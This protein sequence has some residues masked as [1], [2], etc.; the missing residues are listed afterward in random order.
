M[1]G[2]TKNYSEVPNAYYSLYNNNYLPNCYKYLIRAN[3]FHF[4]FTFLETL[5]NII[6]ELYIFL[7]GYNPEK[8]DERNTLNVLTFFPEHI[9]NLSI[10]IKVL[11]VL[12]YLLIF[13]GVYYILGKYKCKKS[14]IYISILFNFIELF[15]FRISMLLFLSVYCCLS[16]LCI[17]IFLFLLVPHIYITF[18]HFHYNH[19]YVFVPSFIIYPFDEFSS[20]FDICSLVIKILF[21]IV[22]Y[23][24]NN[25]LKKNFYV[26]TFIL[27]IIFCIYFINDLINHSYLLMKN[28]ALNKAKVSLFFIQTILLI[29]AQ[30][31]GA[32]GILN[33]SF[34]II[35]IFIFIIVLLYTFMLYDPYHHINIKR[36][37]PNENMIFF[38]FLLS[39]EMEPFIMIE[40]HISIHYEI[41]GICGLCNKFKN[42]LNQNTKNKEE[43]ESLGDLQNYKG[44]EELV[45][46]FFGILYDGRNKYFLLI[47]EMILAYKNKKNY[48]LHICSYL[49][50]N[51]SF[52]KFSE[53]NNNNF[54]L[55]LNIKILLDAM[56]KENKLLDIHESQILQI[57]LCNQFLSLV[58]LTL[59]QIN[60][61]MKSDENK[62][63]KFLNLSISLNKMKNSEYNE[64]LFSHKH[65]NISN[66]RNIIYLCALLYEEIFNT[67][68]NGNP[69]PLRDNFQI[70]EN[71]INTDK[72]D[73]VI[74]LA[75]NLTNKQCKII[76]AGKDLYSY[77]DNNLFDLIPLIFKDYLEKVFISKIV[78]HFSV[79]IK[80]KKLEYNNSLLEVSNNSISR[81]E[82]K[83]FNRSNRKI[84]IKREDS[85]YKHIAR[86]EYMEFNLIISQE[87]KSKSFY[88]LLNLK[89]IPLFNYDYNSY[90]ILLDG[91]FKLYKN[92][93]MTL[94]DKNFQAEN[95]QKILSVSKPEL[96]FPP[97]IYSMTFHKYLSSIEKKNYKL[98]KIFEFNLSKKLITIYS[99]IAKDK[100]AYKKEK[101]KSF[102][103]N[104]TIK[105]KFYNS[106]NHNNEKKIDVNQL[107]KFIEDNASV[108]SQKTVYNNSSYTQGFNL[109]TKRKENIYRDSKLYKIGTALHLM[110]PIIIIF[111]VIEIFHLINLKQGDY[112]NNYSLVYFNEFYKLYFQLFST[113]VSVI[114]IKYNSSCV[115]AMSL[116]ANK[117]NKSENYFNYTQYFY[118]ES[119]VLMKTLLG[120]RNNL[121]NIHQN[122]GEKNFEKIFEQEVNYTRISKIF[123]NGTVDLALMDIKIIFTEAILIAI[124]SFQILTNNT[125]NEEIYLLNKKEKP[126]LY[127][128]NYGN[129]TKNISDYQKEFYEMILNYEIFW[130]QFRYVYYKLL[131]ALSV[132]TKNIKFYIYFYFNFS[133]AIIAFICLMLFCYMQYFEYLVV[134]IMNHI[135][136][137]INT[138]EDNFN[139]FK[140]FSKKIE[141]LNIILKIYCS[142]PIKSIHNLMSS[143]N[144]Y[145]K[146][147]SNKKKNVYLDVNKKSHK[148]LGVNKIYINNFHDIPKHL[149]II[150]KSD[151][152]N[153]KIMLYYYLFFITNFIFI[154]VSYILLY[155]MWQKYYLI[156]DN[157]YSLLKKDTELEISFYKVMNIYDLII[158][159]N[160][161]LDDLAKDIF[162]ESYFKVDD[163][164]QLLNSFYDDLYQVFNYEF[165]IVILVKY[166]AE[167]FPYFFFSCDN[168]YF[169][170]NDYIEL[171][172]LNPEIK[173]IENLRDKIFT[174]C[175]NTGWDFNH[176][177]ANAFAYHHQEVRNAIMLITDFSYEGLINNLKQGLYGQIKLNLNLILNFITDIINV[178][179]HKVEYDNLLGV[180][181]QYLA[182]TIVVIVIIDIIIISIVI[183]F[184]IAR[185]KR[186]CDQFILL[187]QVFKLCEVHEQ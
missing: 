2:K 110:I 28:T 55:V 183:T 65:D 23:T 84:S 126:F 149:K 17:V 59:K 86:Y 159:D 136:M 24:N 180:L 85:F 125:I 31:M 138:K 46:S 73:R 57:T 90:Y 158:F 19:L 111:T 29:Y 63:F 71:L 15:Y 171:L 47:K 16:S 155:F 97:E 80:N 169:M 53:L 51:L 61:V 30:I 177:I 92:T 151:I 1:D 135:N 100:E 20:L 184:Y 83:L 78:E 43:D 4:V 26:I 153:L 178:K 120:R 101:R 166:F 121:L 34:F 13:D 33:I 69:L 95:K 77:K 103:A 116:Y 99:I 108:Q 143:Y 58:D 128:D 172:E 93:V 142:N 72:I 185:L 42:Y 148:N 11:I 106:E 112:I 157:L 163:G 7:K 122:I 140:E 127:F 96:E 76:R 129:N 156:K 88:R 79:K 36:E 119:Q 18:Y 162:H 109:K 6:Q 115:N 141:N 70:L 52:L 41:C 117:Y 3:L 32:K 176:D 168:M 22:G 98:F 87:F 60:N 145:E 68:I 133:Y 131:D 118:G 40:K 132:Q 173:Q 74:S 182:T 48:L 27:Q 75:L 187:K 147:L 175:N 134:N 35:F 150:K 45:N 38:L 164:V 39:N 8:E 9:K 25:Y 81:V 152:V 107:Q 49:F 181:A 165:E 82:N 21:S 62:A 137:V 167:G 91:W 37:T 123:N 105:L 174:I 114:C 12:L 124:N 144:K 154:V 14:N 64:V 67:T 102:S 139:F 50:I 104:E 94:Q 44:K 179:L 89:L 66:S 170:A 5:L 130:V 54:L 146:Y 56:N 160:Y 161:T 113:I 186:L 10:E